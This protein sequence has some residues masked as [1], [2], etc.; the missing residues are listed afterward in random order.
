MQRSAPQKVLRRLPGTV[1]EKVPAEKKSRRRS[2]V[3]RLSNKELAGEAE[4]W[5]RAWEA[6]TRRRV[7]YMKPSEQEPRSIRVFRLKYGEVVES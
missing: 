5:Y 4:L 6:G 2:G 3:V 1:L 7:P